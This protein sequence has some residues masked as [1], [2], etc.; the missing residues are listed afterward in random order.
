[1]PNVAGVYIPFIVYGSSGAQQNLN[2][3]YSGAFYPNQTL[4]GRLYFLPDGSVDG[5]FAS[6]AKFDASR[7]SAEYG[8]QSTV[9]PASA[10]MAFGIYLGH[11][12]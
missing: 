3:S 1:M 7:S 12:A 10:D 9:M 11:T 5:D 6:G 4:E 8:A 2:A